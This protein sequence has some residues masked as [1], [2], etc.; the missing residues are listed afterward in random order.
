MLKKLSSF[1]K[2]SIFAGEKEIFADVKLIYKTRYIKE[3]LDSLPN[4]TLLL[5]KNCQMVFANSAYFKG[6]TPLNYSN[7]IGLQPGDLLECVYRFEDPGECGVTKFCKYCGLLEVVLKSQKTGSKAQGEARISSSINHETSASDFMVTASPLTI[8]NKS[9]TLV[10][11]VDISS[12]KRKAVLERIFFHDLLNKAGGLSWF[13]ENIEFPSGAG[14]TKSMIEI[15]TN[16]SSEIVEEINIYR[17]IM[18]AE[19][20]EL[21]VVWAELQSGEVIENVVKQISC[22]TVSYEKHIKILPESEKVTILT[23]YYLLNRILINMLKNAFEATSRNGLVTISCRCIDSYVRFSV[24]NDRMMNE[25]I[26]QQVFQRSFTT[27]G[28]G[29]GLGTYSMKL[30]GEKYLNGRISFESNEEKGT[31]FWVD[32]PYSA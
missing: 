30:L 5:N 17:S 18:E 15:A 10:Y 12:E 2:L 3:L 9:Y 21:K 7:K 29:R 6:I 4:I 16:L 27:K 31:S 1:F 28:S 22:H 14:K 13:F 32:I 19:S 25:P 8:N 26:S 11:L 23:D 20:G 24:H